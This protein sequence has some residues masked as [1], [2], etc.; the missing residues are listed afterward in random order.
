MA[1]Q[2]FRPPVVDEMRPVLDGIAKNL[3]DRLWGPQGPE[4]GT[5]LSELEHLVVAIREAISEK[6]LHEACQRQAGERERPADFQGCPC[7]GGST[8]AN[9]PEPRVL[10][11]L[12]GHLDWQEPREYCTR[13]RR[14]FFPSV[15]E[16]GN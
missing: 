4:W 3:A 6:M 11:T 15:Q 16:F 7:C 12:G 5:R 8:V 2:K 9:D 10:Q 13:C 1:S 14:A